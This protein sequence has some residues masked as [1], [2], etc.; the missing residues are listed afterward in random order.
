MRPQIGNLRWAQLQLPVLSGYI[1][2]RLERAASEFQ[3]RLVAPG[4]TEATVCLPSLDDPSLML[5]VDGVSILG[6]KDGDYVCISGIGS[7]D[8]TIIRR[9]AKDVLV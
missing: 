1:T 2:L 4:N 8:H 3:M 7:G 5:V 6:S 9:I